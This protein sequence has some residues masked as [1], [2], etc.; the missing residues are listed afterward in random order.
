[1]IT[2]I[3]K[4]LNSDFLCLTEH[5]M[6]EDEINQYSI[7]SDLKLVTSYC[8]PKLKHGG[9]AIYSRLEPTN[10]KVMH[11]FNNLSIELECELACIEFIIDENRPIVLV[12][13]YRSPNGSID[14]FLTTMEK[15]MSSIN[16]LDRDSII[17]GDFNLNFTKL[18]KNAGNFINLCCMYGLKMTIS[19][20]TRG[21]NCLDN[22]F[23][24]LVDDNFKASVKNCHVSDHL[25]QIF[26]LKH[27]IGNTKNCN[28]G[29]PGSVI[30]YSL[31]PKIRIN[32]S[33]IRVFNYYLSKE[34][35]SDLFSSNDI[36]N[37]FKYFCD[38][39]QYYYK[40]SFMYLKKQKRSVRPTSNYKKNIRQTKSEWYNSELQK[41]KEYL[42]SLYNLSKSE[43]LSNNDACSS[44]FKDQYCKYKREYRSKI[45]EAVK[46]HNTLSIKSSGNQT[47]ALWKIVN[48]NN[49]SK[50]ND[51][52]GIFSPDEYNKFFI[53]VAND[54]KSKNNVNSGLDLSIVSRFLNTQYVPDSINLSCFNS[55]TEEDVLQV[56]KNIPSKKSKDHFGLTNHLIKQTIKSFV[57]PFTALVNKCLVQGKFPHVLKVT[58][59]LP[60]FKKGK[61]D[62][63]GNYR[64]ISLV[65]VFSKIIEIIISKQLL[66]YLERNSLLSE[67]QFG[68]RKGLSTTHA[69]IKLTEEI[70]S[71]YESK[72]FAAV[73]FCD[74][75]KAFDCVAHNI[76]IHKLEHLH[77]EDLALQLIKSYLSN[78][79]QYVTVNN[80]SSSLLPIVC[81]VPQGSVLGP[82]LFVIMINDLSA[83][84]PAEVVLYADDTTVKN[85]HVN[86]SLAL[87]SA[88]SNQNLVQNW[89]T[90]N[91]LILNEDKTFTVIFSTKEKLEPL[92]TPPKFL[93]VC[94]DPDLSWSHQVIGLK[95]KLS[96]SIFALKRLCGDL[97]EDGLRLAYFGLFH[98]HISYGLIV[99]GC[100]PHV[101]EIFL[102]QKKAIRIITG[103]KKT[104]H[105]REVFK[106]L[107]IFTL[108]SLYIYQCLL[109]I[110][111]SPDKM[112]LRSN[113]HHHK[114]RYN[115]FIDLP[116]HRLHKSDG[117]ATVMSSRLLNKLPLQ[118]RQLDDCNFQRV[119]RSFLM[120]N[121]FYSLKEF[122]EE[123]WTVANFNM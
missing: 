87:E 17:C 97:E 121:A 34:K 84:I 1:M 71:C 7:I 22:V 64:P 27:R 23:T 79:S 80:I 5:W 31:Q 115:Y 2:N 77:V 74:L 24:S 62:D 101:Q 42:D 107:N 116:K 109:Y 59:V 83:N 55:V 93:G 37:N 14:T 114:T 96:K 10:L 18:D 78:R 92:A 33:N 12:T 16:R 56:V 73:T 118:I 108:Y 103:L 100:A 69:L 75:S 82:L 58:R 72:A 65:P 45:R 19:E 120:N 48:K 20:P 98:A 3:S 102:L 117:S 35:W 99:W 38:T 53:N 54:V 26:T 95:N 4:E 119:V 40:L 66:L 86:R 9:V 28:V 94:L 52:L 61:K 8:R 63:L 25:G 29:L 13:V 70:L 36:N 67:S 51:R 110:R 90:A 113:I 112:S 41:M 85:R 76:L 91:E 122:L 60:V 104:D 49:K 47:K 21:K 88:K 50:T 46:K 68:F 15:L 32:E 106:K 81:G 44:H 123:K 43:S 11:D 39:M 30:E 105:C 57:K 111:A 89:M 6:M